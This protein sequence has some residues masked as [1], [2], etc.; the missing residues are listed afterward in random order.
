LKC[1]IA[2]IIKHATVVLYIQTSIFCNW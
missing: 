1:E 2:N